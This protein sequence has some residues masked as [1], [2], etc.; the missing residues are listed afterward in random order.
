MWRRFRSLTGLL[1]QGASV[2]CIV[3]DS[4]FHRI[5]VPVERLYAEMLA[6]LGCADIRCRPVRKRNSRKE[7]IEFGASA[8][9][10]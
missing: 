8:R 1:N 4:S 5:L 2:H 9:R 6:Q 3:G 10:R 7:L